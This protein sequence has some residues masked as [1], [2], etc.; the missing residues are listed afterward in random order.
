M[1]K[2]KDNNIKLHEFDTVI[3]PRKLWIAISDRPSLVLNNFKCAEILKEEADYEAIDSIATVYKA[4]KKDNDEGGALIIFRNK[5]LMTIDVIAHE[6]Y[7]AA[8]YILC[9]LGMKYVSDTG[10][11]QFA[12]L[13]GWIANCCNQVKT[14]KCEKQ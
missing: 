9:D 3:Y 4:V 5:K 13:I 2:K 1:N 7:H 8:D 12:Y 14:N 11:E 6:S 10:N